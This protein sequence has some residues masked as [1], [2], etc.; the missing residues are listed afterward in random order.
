VSAVSTV[1]L[2]IDGARGDVEGDVAFDSPVG[3]RLLSD[4]PTAAIVVVVEP[5]ADTTTIQA[6]VVAINIDPNLTAAVSQA[7]VQVVVGGSVETLQD[8]RAGDVVA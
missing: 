2:D 1:A 5:L 3:V 4:E 8:L 7:S 6:A